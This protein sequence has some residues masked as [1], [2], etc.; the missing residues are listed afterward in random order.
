MLVLDGSLGEGGGQ[1]LRTALALSLCTGKSFRIEHIRANRRNPGLMRQ[2]LTAVLAAAEICGA[3]VKGAQIGSPAL[4]FAPGRIKAGE[5]R[6]AIGSAGSCTLVFQTILPALLL[7]QTPSRIVMQG[8]THNPWAPPFHFLERAFLRQLSRMGAQVSLE[9]KRFGFYPAGGGEFI[10]MVEPV[11]S[12]LPVDLAARGRLTRAFA[13]SFVA[14]LPL[15][16]AQRELET[17]RKALGWGDEALLL[18]GLSNDQGPGNALAITLEYEHVTEVFTGFGQKGVT[19]ETVAQ[20][21]IAEVRRF[22]SSSAAVGPFLADQMLLPM[23]LA[24]SGSFTTSELTMHTLT[25]AQV[26]R[27]FLTVDIQTTEIDPRCHEVRILS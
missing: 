11:A 22:M 12:L 27:K 24:G 16:V 20:K 25:N 15:H 4:E 21:V 13:E 23:A 5:Y 3:E 9:L 1:I 18:R 14:A 17:V 8:G 19:A 2:H 7:A 10:A 6:F 26:I